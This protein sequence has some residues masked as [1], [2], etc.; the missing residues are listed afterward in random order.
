[1]GLFRKIGT[2]ETILHIFTGGPLKLF[3][4]SKTRKACAIWAAHKNQK[5]G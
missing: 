2:S 3:Y 5:K 4:E 1:M